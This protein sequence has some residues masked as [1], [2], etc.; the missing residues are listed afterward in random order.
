MSLA[1]KPYWE[2]RAKRAESR[3]VTLTIKVARLTE[4]LE[5]ARGG[6]VSIKQRLLRLFR[7][8]EAEQIVEH[9]YDLMR[10]KDAQ[11]K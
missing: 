4:A 6:P 11:K 5:R 2:G 9:T 10:E 3:V 8:E 7:F 1:Y